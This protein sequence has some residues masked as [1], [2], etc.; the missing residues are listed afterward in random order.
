MLK[1]I[2]LT[3]YPTIIA[4]SMFLTA[5][6][7]SDSGSTSNPESPETVQP[8]QAA[9][10]V[11]AN[12]TTAAVYEQQ[13]SEINLAAA[14]KTSDGSTPVLKSVT[15]IS[16]DPQCDN[17]TVNELS[18]TLAAGNPGTCVYEYQASEQSLQ[19]VAIAHTQVAIS[20]ADAPLVTANN[21]PTISDAFEIGEEK[22]ISLQAPADMTLS[23][24]VTV[25]GS[26]L[27][28]DVDPVANTITYQ[29]GSN[30]SDAGITRIHYHYENDEELIRMGVIDIAVS[31][32][33][34]NQAPVAQNWSYLLAD[35]HADGKSYTI[36]AE[37]EVITV[38]LANVLL[39]TGVNGS[40]V[41]DADSEDTLQ[42]INVQTFN[43]DVAL[44]DA[45]AFDNLSFTFK[46]ATSGRYSVSYQVS[47]HHG[48]YAL[49]IIEFVVEGAWPDVIVEESGDV[50]KAPVT[51]EAAYVADYDVTGIAAEAPLPEG[52]GYPNVPTY[53]W[54][55]ANH[56][57]R[58]RG[59]S[60]PT[61]TQLNEFLRQEGNPFLENDG[62]DFEMAS[63]WPVERA[64]FT[65][66]F[67]NSDPNLVWAMFPKSSPDGGYLD[68]VSSGLDG[69]SEP[70]LG[71]LVCIDK[72][73]QSL[74]IE[75]T[76]LVK[77]I[78]QQL[79]ASFETASGMSFPYTK[80]LYW[81]VSEPEDDQLTAMEDIANNVTLDTYT[82][83]FH[84]TDSGYINVS[85]QTPMGD[86]ST[87]KD[88]EVINNLLLQGAD[89]TFESFNVVSPECKRDF[90]SS[91]DHMGFHYA[92]TSSGYS[93]AHDCEEASDLYS[94]L[95]AAPQG[96]NYLYLEP[97][98]ATTLSVETIP[99]STPLNFKAGQK[100]RFTFWFHYDQYGQNGA[101][102]LRIIYFRNAQNTV[103]DRCQILDG[104]STVNPNGELTYLQGDG[105]INTWTHAACEFTPDEDAPGSYMEI[106]AANKRLFID[107]MV[108]LPVE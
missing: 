87:S 77:G 108:L 107:D 61:S 39:P 16:D 37:Q 13:S 44:L 51:L 62:N 27:V 2:R 100:Y 63:G 15:A 85:V 66:T 4:L 1:P 46:A 93:L 74:N 56:I 88:L 47:D 18:F 17:I 84:A 68:R 36:V 19:N 11:A 6:G 101:G 12:D 35:D 3:A 81:S 7:G 67:D 95:V 14:I 96:G 69:V 24:E 98:N 70:Y 90:I 80:P 83:A 5:C 52:N 8:P 102:G 76:F 55:A 33:T 91:N 86:L 65:S 71:Y 10:S 42:L 9:A 53:T 97:N 59:G 104:Y 48:G 73:P 20:G 40:L 99:E 58:A 79:T 94:L 34:F 106:R 105:S 92:S 75:N 103:I 57:C 64:Y 29:A 38:D 82:G 60:L 78:D 49:G 26:G 32:D 28:T 41:S 54:E 22:T 43:A 21:L 31:T 23:T 72:T 45:T 30:E 89:P 50:F 25:L